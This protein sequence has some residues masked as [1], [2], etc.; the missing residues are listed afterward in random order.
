MH[1][2]RFAWIGW[3][4]WPRR[5]LF[6]ATLEARQHRVSTP[7]PPS[8]RRQP[9]SSATSPALPPAGG[10]GPSV[11]RT[12]R[13][14]GAGWLSHR[15]DGRFDGLSCSP[16]RTLHHA[17]AGRSPEYEL[18]GEFRNMILTLTY[19]STV[20]QTVDRGCFSFLLIK[21]G[22]MLEGQGAFYYSPEHQ[23]KAAPVILSRKDTHTPRQLS[24]RQTSESYHWIGPKKPADTM[25]RS[26]P[27]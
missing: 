16:V 20:P 27:N 21:N 24:K 4:K 10:L 5:T 3:W 25:F 7:G 15:H 12:Q 2:A 22:R 17:I 9:A 13:D 14:P 1:S 11:Q 26:Q 18:E 8:L 19:A 23:I 6:D